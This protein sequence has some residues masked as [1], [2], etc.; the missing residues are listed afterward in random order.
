MTFHHRKS[1]LVVQ[2]MV[3]RPAKSDFNIRPL[4]DKINPR[5]NCQ[6]RPK[7]IFQDFTCIQSEY[8]E[9]YIQ[10]LIYISYSY[11]Y[12]LTSP[13]HRHF[14]L[15]TVSCQSLPHFDLQMVGAQSFYYWQS[16]RSLLYTYS[17]TWRK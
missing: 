1:A 16:L 5:G 12:I 13:L 14:T 7:A 8:V 15:S 4:M 6:E 17:C 10:F 3:C 9:N 11:Q 2:Y